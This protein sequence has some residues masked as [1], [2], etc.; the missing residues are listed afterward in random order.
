MNI[1]E[2]QAKQLFEKFQ[3]ATPRGAPASTP[4]QAR[5]VAA[6]LGVHRF[7]V[8]AQ[9]HAG[10]RGKGAFIDGFCGGV[11]LCNSTEQ[12]A[13]M[14]SQMLGN[15]LVT[16]QTGSEGQIVHQV[17]IAE[18]VGISKECYLAIVIDRET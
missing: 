9:I 16:C 18:S 2:Y 14:A 13:E 11:H 6:K 8:K 7:D 17:L 1:H 10:G 12:V 15:T 3:V 4:N 5:E